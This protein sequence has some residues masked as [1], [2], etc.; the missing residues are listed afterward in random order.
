MRH[1]GLK[2]FGPRDIFIF[3]S[4]LHIADIVRR[5]FLWVLQN[6]IN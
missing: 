3:D 5:Q 2:A 6:I 4:A 1:W